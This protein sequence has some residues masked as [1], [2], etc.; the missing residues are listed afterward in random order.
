LDNEGTVAVGIG[1]PSGDREVFT[2]QP[3]QLNTSISPVENP[4]NL[5]PDFAHMDP[6]KELAARRSKQSNVAHRPWTAP[7][8]GG[9]GVWLG[10]NGRFAYIETRG[11]ALYDLVIVEAHEASPSKRVRLDEYQF[12]NSFFQLRPSPRG[13][14]LAICDSSPAPRVLVV[15]TE[16]SKAT[17]SPAVQGGVRAMQFSADGALLAISTSAGTSTQVWS[18]NSPQMAWV[19]FSRPNDKPMH[20][21]FLGEGRCLAIGYR[22]GTVVFSDLDTQKEV[23]EFTPGVGGITGISEVAGRGLLLTS[24]DEGIVRWWK[25]SDF[26]SEIASKAEELVGLMIFADGTWVVVSPDGRFDT[27]KL[28]EITNLHWFMPDDPLRALPLEIFMREYYEPR[29]LPR[30]LAG[31]KPREIGALDKVNRAQP[32]VEIVGVE[33]ELDAQGR[34]SDTVRVNVKVSGASEEFGPEGNK[35]RIQTGAYDLRVFRDGQLVGRRPEARDTE[36]VSKGASLEQERAQW[37]KAHFVVGLEQGAKIV[38]FPGVRLPR[39]AD[40]KEVSF[41]AYAFNEDRVKSQ[42]TPP[43]PLAITK[44]LSSR[45]GRAYVITVGVNN[46]QNPDW[47]LRYAG[48]DAC[49]LGQALKRRFTKQLDEQGHKRYEQVVWVPLIS[50][51]RGA[52]QKGCPGSSN[53][54]TKDKIRAVLERLSGKEVEAQRLRGVPAA[55]RLQPVHPEDTVVVAFSTHGEV[56][57]Q[58]LFYLLPYDIGPKHAPGKDD[59]E[60][61]RERAISSEELSDWVRGI[62]ALNMVMIVDA[63]H[64]AASVES[65]EFKPGPMGSRG[66]GQLAYDKRMRILAASRIGE[67]A[68]ETPDTRLGLLTYALVRQGLEARGAD[69]NHDGKILLSEWLTYANDEVPKIWRSWQAGTFEGGLKGTKRLAKLDDALSHPSGQQPALFDFGGQRDLIIE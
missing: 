7:S 33:R 5:G 16:T 66:L 36:G 31:E 26:C 52:K 53:D 30:L 17:I 3:W 24:G 9:V 59:N 38:S 2:V 63:C 67:Y 1:Q 19:S 13:D 11:P 15:D 35:R 45:A 51:T 25:R 40:I 6:V 27:N 8:E 42:T 60:T 12:K 14:R 23:Y 48:N 64:S 39:R 68:I 32:K 50:N 65:R 34:P 20:A 55:N 28:E 49:A 41:T 61:R 62:D 47:D 44:E 46:F 43:Y 21:Q 58:G 29:L 22:S 56:D 69:Y 10:V 54:A 57:E 37:R 4:L 18:V